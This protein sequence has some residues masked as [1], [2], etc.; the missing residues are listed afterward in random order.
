M[1]RL[2][3]ATLSSRPYHVLIIQERSEDGVKMK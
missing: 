1:L 2:H 3:W